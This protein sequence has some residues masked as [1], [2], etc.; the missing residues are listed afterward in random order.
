MPMPTPIL[1]LLPPNLCMQ[2]ACSLTLILPTLLQKRENRKEQQHLQH[3]QQSLFHL[4]SKGAHCPYLQQQLPLQQ[5]LIILTLFQPRNNLNSHTSK[6]KRIN[7]QSSQDTSVP[8]RCQLLVLLAQGQAH[9]CPL[10]TLPSTLTRV[11]P[12]HSKIPLELPGKL[13]SSSLSFPSSR[14]QSPHHW[15]KTPTFQPLFTP[16]NYI[17]RTELL[18]VCSKGNHQNTPPY[19]HKLSLRLVFPLHFFFNRFYLIW[20]SSTKESVDFSFVLVVFW[21]KRASVML[22]LA[23]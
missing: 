14:H 16:W 1:V 19:R 6:W 3:L 22:M 2:L 12:L 7:Q 9:K 5:A 10:T 4:P 11:S 20:L 18:H 8:T 15:L 13:I 23:K 17:W 21:I